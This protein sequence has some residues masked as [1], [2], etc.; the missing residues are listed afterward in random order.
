MLTSA[1]TSAIAAGMSTVAALAALGISVM[2]LKEIKRGVEMQKLKSARELDERLQVR[3]DPL[4]PGLRRVLG[5][6]EDGVP[7]EIRQT[8]IDFFVLYSDCFAAARDK[9]LNEGDWRGFELELRYWAQ[10]PVAQRAWKAFRKQEWTD[11]FVEYIDEI[12]IG[13]PAYPRLV[14]LKDVIPIIDWPEDEF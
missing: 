1:T 9:L 4:Y 8:L 13:P 2:N 6:I 12:L 10:K 3:L 7:K 14:T 5:H 11:G